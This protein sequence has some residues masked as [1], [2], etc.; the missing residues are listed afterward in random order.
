MNIELMIEEVFNV[1][2][3]GV[4]FEVWGERNEEGTMKIKSRWKGR[5]GL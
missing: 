5:N 1:E 4:E 2:I 3:E